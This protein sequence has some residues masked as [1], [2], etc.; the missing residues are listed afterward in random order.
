MVCSWPE[1]EYTCSRP[2]ICDSSFSS[3]FFDR[4][5][6]QVRRADQY[7]GHRH[8]DL[9]LFLAGGEDQ[10]DRPEKRR[11]RKKEGRQAAVQRITDDSIQSMRG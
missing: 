4:L 1:R 2:A 3:V 10:R 5:G 11:Q 6:R 8:D 9:R 7:V